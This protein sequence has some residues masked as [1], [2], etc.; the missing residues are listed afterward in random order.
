MIFVKKM[1]PCLN[2]GINLLEITVR[3]V[4]LNNSE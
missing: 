3:N 4:K 1:E 2:S